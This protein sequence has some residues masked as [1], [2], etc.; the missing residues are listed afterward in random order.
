M[1]LASIGI[2]G[3][4]A[5]SFF[6][7]ISGITLVLS[8]AFISRSIIGFYIFFEASLI[9]IFFIVL[10]WGYQPERLQASNYLMLYT[11][12]GRLPLILRILSIYYRGGRISF[13]LSAY[14][15][16]AP[17]IYRDYILFFFLIMAFL[18]KAPLYF[19]HLWLPKAHVEA[20]VA[21]SMIL[22]GVLLK[23]GGYGLI[24]FFQIL[25]CLSFRLFRAFGTVALWGGGVCALICLRQTDVK[26]LIAYSSVTHMGVI[27]GG[28]FRRVV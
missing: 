8:I 22:A 10:G 11:V 21:G 27:I 13:F 1:C 2:G 4:R 14:M 7:L 25:P 26:A 28:A 12:T 3:K 6:K 24:R 20:P 18:I 23:L 17:I 9:P 19:V 5:L 16:Y 15:S